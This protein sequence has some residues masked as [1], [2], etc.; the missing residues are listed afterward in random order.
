MS[1]AVEIIEAYIDD[2]GNVCYSTNDFAGEY[3]VA[4]DMFKFVPYTPQ[5][6]TL[7]VLKPDN[8]FEGIHMRHDYPEFYEDMA[9]KVACCI[10]TYW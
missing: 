9:F 8:I 7:Y 10:E 3:V 6:G 1:I 4:S 5:V 2:E